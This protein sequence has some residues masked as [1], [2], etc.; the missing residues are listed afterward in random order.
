MPRSGS[1]VLLLG[2]L[3]G[4]CT[5]DFGRPRPSVWSDTI[6]PQIGFWAATARGEAASHFRMTDDEDQMRDRAWRFVMPGHERSFFQGEVSA[7]AYARILPVQAQSNQVADYHNAL[8]SGSFASQ[9]SRYAR[10]AE[11]ANADRL[12][13]APFRAN[14]TRVVSADRTRLRVAEGSSLVP[15]EKYDPAFARVVENEGLILWVCERV[16]FRIESYRYALANLVVEMPSHEA[17][18]AERGI[19][20]LEAEAVPLCKLPLIGVFGGGAGGAKSAP[21]QGGGKAVVYK[22]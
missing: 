4:S 14:A 18:R 22:G 11:D 7:L 12:L 9:A 6:A 3:A 19:M 10:L 13:I 17:I 1:A 2:L 5:G 15:P 16:R 21:D 8:V 20:A